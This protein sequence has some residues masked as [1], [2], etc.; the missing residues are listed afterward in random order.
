MLSAL[1]S[2]RFC[3]GPCLYHD[4]YGLTFNAKIKNNM[5]II[6]S[7]SH[8]KQRASVLTTLCTLVSPFLSIYLVI[9]NKEVI[10]FVNWCIIT[11]NQQWNIILHAIIS[12]FTLQHTETLIT[13]CHNPL[14]PQLH[15]IPGGRGV[16][17]T[18]PYKGLNYILTGFS[19]TFML[20]TMTIQGRN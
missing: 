12:L 10:H 18:V 11:D 2:S 15:W 6:P 16:N 5:Y 14:P 19:R 3:E 20:Y 17:G 8:D 13:Y 1:A 7:I 9:N 4:N